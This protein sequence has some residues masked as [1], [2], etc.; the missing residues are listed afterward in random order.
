M[1]G[2]DLCRATHEKAILSLTRPTTQIRI[3]VRHDP[4]PEGFQ[5]SHT[6]PVVC[7]D[8]EPEG[9]QVSH[10]EPVVCHDTEPEGFQVSHI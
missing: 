7:H 6:W 9:F 5:V 2:D 3:V 10:T 4:Q 8:T 1:N